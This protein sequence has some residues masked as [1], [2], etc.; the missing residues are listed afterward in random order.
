[1]PYA[2]IDDSIGYIAPETAF[3]TSLFDEDFSEDEGTICSGEES[4]PLGVPY[5]R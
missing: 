4:L 3:R 1:M 5:V 2:A